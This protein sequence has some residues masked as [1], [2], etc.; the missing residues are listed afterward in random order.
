MALGLLV[1]ALAAAV[2]A[3]FALQN[4]A[5]TTVRFLTWTVEAVP[6]AG[7][8]LVALAVGLLIAGGPLALLVWRWRSRARGLQA[9][10]ASL[11]KNA[12]ERRPPASGQGRMGQ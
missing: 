6:L 11:E 1:A 4:G 3:V 9:R 7:V 8:V 12:T 5:P 10:V 2:V